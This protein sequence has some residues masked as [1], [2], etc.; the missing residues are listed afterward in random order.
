MSTTKIREALSELAGLGLSAA[1]GEALAEVEAIE[2]SAKDMVRIRAR[3][4]Q[5]PNLEWSEEE[6]RD[7]NMIDA[8]ME[9]I[10]KDAP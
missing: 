1:A 4:K 3:L 6:M 10:A 7:A 5:M 8:V 9:S 2:R